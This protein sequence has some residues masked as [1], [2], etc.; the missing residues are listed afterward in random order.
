MLSLFH[1]IVLCIQVLFNL[2]N[3][4]E[5]NEMFTEAINSYNVIVK[6]KMF[7]NAGM[8]I[9]ACFIFIEFLGLNFFCFCNQNESINCSTI[10]YPTLIW[11]IKCIWLNDWDQG[12]YSSVF[13]CEVLE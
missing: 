2:A 3:Q 5:A 13:A 12:I 4:Y 9:L 7:S 8:T 10:L 11:K 6:N 1:C